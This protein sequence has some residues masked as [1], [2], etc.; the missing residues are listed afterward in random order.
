[1][2]RERE[3]CGSRAPPTRG[4]IGAGFEGRRARTLR[5][6]V[7]G[8]CSS[9]PRGAARRR[10]FPRLM[11]EMMK[12]LVL[13]LVLAGLS[14]V[15]IHVT[16]AAAAHS[17]E[18]EARALISA[19]LAEMGGED[20]LRSIKSVM[21]EGV[22]HTYF[23]EQSERPEGP[24]VVSY[25]QVTE[26]RDL[27]NGSLLRTAESRNFQSPQWR[28]GPAIVAAGGAVMMKFG[29]RSGPGSPTQAR[30]AQEALGLSPERVLLTA[31]GSA[32]L[33]AEADTVLQGVR[34]HVVAF[35][36]HDATARV[37]VS[38]HTKLPT[39]TKLVRAYP[40]DF[41]WGVW[42]DVHTRTY[43]SLWTLEPGGIRYPRQANVERNG[44]PFREFTV[45]AIRLNEPIPEGAFAVAEGARKAFAA[46]GAGSI[47]SM[48]LGNPNMPRAEIAP[49]VVQI[50]GL[51]NVALVRQSDGGVV[52]E[53]PISSGYSAKV[54]AEAERRFP[55]LPVKAVVSTS[56]AW[57]HIGGVRQY[58]ARGIPVYAL[59]LNRPIL[60]RLIA[61]PRR[62]HPDS[63]ARSPRRPNWRLVSGKTVLGGGPNRMELYP[64][65]S[66]SG[67]RMLMI[68]FPE[69][70]LLYGSDLVQ[71]SAGGGAFFMPQYLTELAA[72]A[73]R[74]KLAVSG[75]FA[76]HLRLR[77]W[78]EVLAAIEKAG[79]KN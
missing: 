29:E 28:K 66:E 33:R 37:Y 77:P 38:A 61:S 5:Y 2:A 54:I 35:S 34:Q 17:R 53:A 45:T 67:E 24:W 26:L 68:Y 30:E 64:I 49:G 42:G 48:P 6:L 23:V 20:K 79:A 76:M 44:L 57:P 11:K 9:P 25:E 32:D 60:E 7:S 74:E 36:W 21:I 19:A 22:G 73:G 52:V 15:T 39:A 55:G 3:P 56:D 70:R 40:D 50:P 14:P 10:N 12:Y 69:H 59:D 47:D 13:A 31:L 27:S 72:A 46:R 8:L 41:F 1:M 62:A 51:W 65:R 71:Q 43:H 18:T 4:V 63:L 58:V 16:T 78:G 75:V